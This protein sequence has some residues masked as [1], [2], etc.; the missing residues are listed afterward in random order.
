MAQRGRSYRTIF[1]YM[2]FCIVES[3]RNLANRNLCSVFCFLFTRPEMAPAA[4]DAAINKLIYSVLHRLGDKVST[5]VS[6]RVTHACAQLSTPAHTPRSSLALSISPMSLR[7]PAI[8]ETSSAMRR[9]PHPDDASIELALA[10]DPVMQQ[11]VQ[12]ILALASSRINLIVT[13]LV[14]MAENMVRAINFINGA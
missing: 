8:A 14:T 3:K 1:L 12:S 9:S 6:E 2:T 10:S 11:T 13:A 7:S 5:S 4:G